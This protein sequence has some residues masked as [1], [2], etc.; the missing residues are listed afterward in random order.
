[1]S[2]RMVEQRVVGAG[3][4]PDVSRGTFGARPNALASRAPEVAK[5][6]RVRRVFGED[7]NGQ[8]WRGY[9]QDCCRA[10]AIPRELVIGGGCVESSQLNSPHGWVHGFRKRERRGEL[11]RFALSKW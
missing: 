2:A 4:E 5:T 9:D 10:I 6:Q 3:C 8:W 11:V 7:L 1:M